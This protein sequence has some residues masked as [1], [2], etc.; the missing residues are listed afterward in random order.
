MNA[1]IVL[2][3]SLPLL[4][5][6]SGWGQKLDGEPSPLQRP[7]TPA[8]GSVA[9]I[10]PP[11]FVWVPAGSNLTYCLQVSPSDDFS[12]A[13]TRST[14]GLDTSIHSLRKPLGPG[15]WFW[16]YGVQKSD[17]SVAWSRTR[18]FTVPKDVR[19]WPFPDVDR[20]IASVPLTRPR[21]FLLTNQVGEYRRRCKGDLRNSCRSL[22]RR[23]DRY[24]GQELVPEPAYVKGSGPERGRNYQRVFRT[25]RPPM[26][27]MEQCGLAYLLTGERKYGVEAKRRILHFF[28]WDPEGST[29]LFHNDEPAMW[30]MM[31]GVRAYDWTYDLFAP[32]E[33]RK[34]ES[35]MRIRAAQFYKRLHG[36]FESNPHDS[37]AGRIL[38]FLGEASLAFCREWPEAR[39]WLDY[40]LQVFR[41]VYPAWATDDGGWHE[42]PS[43]WSYYMSFVLHFVVPLRNAAGIDL[44]E[45]PFFRNTPYYKL[46]TNPP[47]ARISPFGDGEH[48]GPS[49]SMG[50]LMYQFSA[51]LNDPYIGWYADSMGADAGAGP[52]GMVLAGKAPSGK[53]PSALPPNRYFPGVGLVS[54]HTDLGDPKNDIHFLF[55]SD[56]YGTIS[57]AHADENAFTI[58]AFG[59]ALAIK[60]GYYP[61]YGSDHHRNWS[62]QTRSS[63]CITV[64]GGKGQ[65]PHDPR[66]KGRILA[67][68][69]SD[70]YDYVAGDATEAYRG[71]LSRFH[72]HIVHVRPGIFVIFDDL[73]APEKV[74]YEWWLHALSEMSLDRKN[75]SLV[76]SQGGARLR[77]QFFSP[78]HLVFLQ[79]N[80]FPDP[81]EW[82]EKNQWHLFAATQEKIQEA[83][84]LTVLTVYRG[85]EGNGLPRSTFVAGDGAIGV[86]VATA[87][88]ARHLVGFRVREGGTVTLGGKTLQDGIPALATRLRY[89][90]RPGRRQTL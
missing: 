48:S 41:A 20:A 59:E 5:P 2:L 79:T 17:D 12:S 13:A 4:V 42:G 66:A 74:T 3:L 16:R 33:R 49:R 63:N 10:N 71:L 69:S 9:T 27:A 65:R 90:P 78:G 34:V 67:F 60:S 81:P 72:R 29:S 73:A 14:R 77:V 64:N 84:F 50:E 11:S 22:C 8:D 15:K 55:H 58:E 47:Y 61:W 85:G 35:V 18:S 46:Y 54:L 1:R 52:L 89:A 6:V 31:R 38:G 88:G 36:R 37:H 82:G 40:V 28:S 19:L 53:N 23:C 83:K 68:Q 30:M 87:P 75:Q 44:M 24:I 56:P 70:V 76:I 62:W 21:L 86:E 45:K 51:L 57:H 43:Y 39:Q 25:T 32:S 7:Y 26:D 80:Q